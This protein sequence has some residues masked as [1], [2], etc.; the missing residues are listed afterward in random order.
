MVYTLKLTQ[1][2]AYLKS[3]LFVAANLLLPYLFHLI[4]G[5]GIMF[6][7]I[8]FFTLVAAQRY[9]YQVALLTAVMTPILGNLIGGA[10]AAAMIPDMLFKGGSLAMF[11]YFMAQKVENKFLA[12]LTAVLASWAFVGLVELPFTGA[13]YAFQDFVTGLPGMAMMVL[14]SW[15]INKLIKN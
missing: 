2:D 10:P 1:T 3:A 12:S 9:G 15:G 11:G 7:P 6:L 5:G 14:G 8:Y 13:A 4:P